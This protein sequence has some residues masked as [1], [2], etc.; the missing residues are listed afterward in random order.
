M[1]FSILA[2]KTEPR[3]KEGVNAHPMGNIGSHTSPSLISVVSYRHEVFLY[4]KSAC[5]KSL[6]C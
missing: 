6:Y 4:V 2:S 5:Q 1:V 3:G